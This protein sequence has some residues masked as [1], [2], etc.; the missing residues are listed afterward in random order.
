VD[1]TALDDAFFSRQTFQKVG[2]LTIEVALFE[3]TG[4]LSQS[5]Q[6]I[7]DEYVA[8][9]RKCAILNG[10]ATNLLGHAQTLHD[11][12]HSPYNNTTES[13]REL[14]LANKLDDGSEPLAVLITSIQDYFNYLK[15]RHIVTTSSQLSQHVWVSVSCSMDEVETLLRGTK[16]TT[17]SFFDLMIAANYEASVETIE[18]NLQT[19]RT[20]IDLQDPVEFEI[21]AAQLDGNFKREIPEGL[22]VELGI[23]FTDGD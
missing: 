4:N 17:F 2:L 20:S 12:W 13:Y 7:V 14:F 11:A 23:H 6:D 15:Q 8:T 21:S 18:A 22:E 3:T 19:I 9:A 16:Q 10:L 5:P 1:S